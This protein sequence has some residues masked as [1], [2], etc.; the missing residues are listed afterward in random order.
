MPP[1]RASLIGLAESY[2]PL[3]G[4]PGMG[5][6]N[7]SGHTHLMSCLQDPALSERQALAALRSYVDRV[8]A[9]HSHHSL[10][11]YPSDVS[12]TDSDYGVAV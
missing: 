11:N 10:S 4:N 5:G 1:W 2:A 8:H 7:S 12:E 6:Y 9:L 3:G